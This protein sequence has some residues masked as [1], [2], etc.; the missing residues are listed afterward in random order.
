[1]NTAVQLRSDGGLRCELACGTPRVVVP[2]GR[3]PVALFGPGE[4]VG[5][6]VESA[7][8]TSLF[9]FRTLAVDDS[10]AAAVP[11][12]FPR[13]RLLLLAR[14]A[15]R[16]RAVRRLFAHL[17]RRAVPPSQLSDAFY[18]R[19]SVAVGGRPAPAG[20]RALVR[21]EL[22]GQAQPSSDVRREGRS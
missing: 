12:V 21:R 2:A 16:V 14:T 1:V 15:A 3:G 8:R 20:L 6:V 22:E 18:V 9:V 5:Y 7:A 13:V 4:I 10:L 19:V 11:G 17:G